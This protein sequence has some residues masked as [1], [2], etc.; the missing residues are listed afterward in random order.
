MAQSVNQTKH[1]FLRNMSSVLELTL[2]RF[3]ASL[4][5]ILLCLE[6]GQKCRPI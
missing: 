5:S 4:G 3:H 1:I 6:K 2:F